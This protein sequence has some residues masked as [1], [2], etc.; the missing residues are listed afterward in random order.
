M[1]NVGQR[2]PNFFL[3]GVP[4]SGSTSLHRYLQQHPDVYMSPIK[5]PHYF[6]DEVRLENF[7]DDFRR[8]AEP[9][10]Q[11]LRDYLAGPMTTGCSAGPVSE[12]PDYVRLFRHASVE[13]AVGEASVCYLWSQTAA[14]N[15]AARIPD[16]KML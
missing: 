1:H 3:A 8:R 11:V 2:L 13:K 14:R 10:Q 5:E 4:K 15:I 12:W 9:M 6:A 16:A 7:G